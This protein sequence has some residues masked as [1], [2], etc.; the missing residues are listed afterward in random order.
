MRWKLVTWITVLATGLSAVLI[1]KRKLIHPLADYAAMPTDSLGK[2]LYLALKKQHINLKTNLIRHDLKHI[3]L[4]YTMN[5]PDELRIHAF[6]MGNRC[7]NPMAI[8]YMLICVPLVPEIIPTLKKD[9]KRGRKTPTLKK[10]D[11]Q[12]FALENV[13]VC[14]KKLHIIPH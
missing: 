4:G 12:F 1:R 8:L 10:T 3:L 11:L 6:L 5:M 2:T 7:Y 14:R 13:E 9:F